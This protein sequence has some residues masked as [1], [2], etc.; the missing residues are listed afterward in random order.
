MKKTELCGYVY[1][2]SVYYNST[3]I[4]DIWDIHKNLMKE[5]NITK[6]FRLIKQVLIALFS[7][8]GSLEI[9]CVF[10]NNELCMFIHS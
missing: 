7:F 8:G 4:D 2:S 10:L 5:H 1:G 6:M 3:D 9:K